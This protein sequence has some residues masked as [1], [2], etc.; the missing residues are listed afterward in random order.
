MNFIDYLINFVYPPRCCI[1][2]KLT[3]FLCDAIVCDECAKEMKYVG[4]L[5]DYKNTLEINL[6]QKIY[7]DYGMAVLSY[8]FVK[9][10]IERYKY[11]GERSIGKQYAKIMYEY[12]KHKNIFENVD[13]IASVPLSH[14]RLKTRGYNQAE[15][16][17]KQL[18]NILGIK[19]IDVL[20][21]I[22]TTKPQNELNLNERIEN[23]KGAFKTKNVDVSG[24]NIVIIDDIFTTGS[25]INECAAALKCAGANKVGFLTLAVSEF[26]LSKH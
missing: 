1:C 15:Y 26:N 16:M 23:V 22:R 21:R 10:S 6:G 3:G 25:T 20:E 4:D 14:K 9:K 17:A 2:G 12:V 11:F 19:Y 24:K 8:S 13:F 5:A 7:F 18:A